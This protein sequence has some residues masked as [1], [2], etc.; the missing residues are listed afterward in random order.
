VAVSNLYVQGG[1]QLRHVT[2]FALG[3]A[4][5]NPMFSLVFPITERLAN[6]LE[7]Q[8]FLVRTLPT[9]TSPPPQLT[10]PHH[11]LLR[12][13]RPR[14]AAC[15]PDC[16]VAG[17]C[18][19]ADRTRR[20]V[21]NQDSEALVVTVVSGGPFQARVGQELQAIVVDEVEEVAG[22]EREQRDAVTDAAGKAAIQVSFCGRGRPRSCAPAASRP[23]QRATSSSYGTIGRRLIRTPRPDRRVSPHRRTSA[24]FHSSA[25]VT[26][27]SQ[28]AACST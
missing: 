20:I 7:P 9:M 27:L 12:H 11:L 28:L 6:R 5:Y 19:R 4:V 17:G 25:T 2:W 1:M 24:H 26:K 16:S 21:R 15:M 10:R 23:Q 18:G 13:P 3:L 22:V 14:A 8:W